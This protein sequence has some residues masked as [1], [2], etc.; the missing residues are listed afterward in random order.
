MQKQG[1]RKST[2]HYCIQALKSIARKT[3][4]LQPESA[5]SYL[6]SAEI[7][8]SRKAK[9]AKDLARFYAHEDLPFSKPNYRRIERLPFVPLE[10]EVGRSTEHF[11]Y[12]NTCAI[13]PPKNMKC[14]QW[15]CV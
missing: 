11:R 1:Y 5:K 7:S 2:V 3:I 6:A 14:P 13:D 8:E 4:L 15:L 12:W 10:V 9:L